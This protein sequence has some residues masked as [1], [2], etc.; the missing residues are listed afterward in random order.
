MICSLCQ[1]RGCLACPQARV[2]YLK[3]LTEPAFVARTPEDLDLLKQ[4][5]GA[6]E[7]QRIHAATG[8]DPQRMAAEITYNLGVAQFIQGM[9]A[10]QNKPPRRARI[11]KIPTPVQESPDWM[12]PQ[13]P[14]R[15][16]R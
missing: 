2:R 15:R 6:E 11:Y 10:L 4:A 7:L 1:D 9:H 8:G 5:V 14:K 3:R 13:F 16:R 12:Q